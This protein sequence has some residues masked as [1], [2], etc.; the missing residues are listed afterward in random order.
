MFLTYRGVL[1]SAAKPRSPR[2]LVSI[3]DA[4]PPATR[5]AVSHLC[6]EADGSVRVEL[7][8]PGAHGEAIRDNI[9]ETWG[10]VFGRKTSV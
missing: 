6:I 7:A 2:P 10:D 8:A 1:L 4:L 9:S 5:S 3:V